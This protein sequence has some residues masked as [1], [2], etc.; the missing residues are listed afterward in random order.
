MSQAPTGPEFGEVDAALL[1]PDDTDN[2]R[3]RSEK[4]DGHHQGHSEG[5]DT[6][7][8]GGYRQAEEKAH[9]H[10]DQEQFQT[11]RV[12][13]RLCG[14]CGHFLLRRLPNCSRTHPRSV[15][16]RPSLSASSTP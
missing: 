8:D 7:C 3:W 13:T 4:D 16:Y 9:G 10:E 6:G 11:L 1:H 14:F 5:S 15:C 12:P 2:N